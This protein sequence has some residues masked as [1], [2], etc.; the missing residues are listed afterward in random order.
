[1][2]RDGDAKSVERN[3]VPARLVTIDVLRGIAATWVV[4][5]HAQGFFR[6]NTEA[7][8]WN[9]GVFDLW[10]EP[11]QQMVAFLLF[12]TGFLGVPLFFVIS[13][14][15]IHLPFAA[16]DRR[17]DPGS[18]AKRRLTRLYPAY[19]AT[20]LAGFSMAV[21]RGGLGESPATLTN[22]AGHLFFWH[23]DWP[24]VHDGA[25]FT[26]VLWSIVVEVHFYVLYAFLLGT[27]RRIGVGT[28]SVACL[29]IGVVYRIAWFASGLEDSGTVALLEPH[30]FALARLG[31]WLLGAWAAE[32]YASGR[33]GATT[34]TRLLG[35]G[36]VIGGLSL[37][38]GSVLFVAF[39]GGAQTT[40]E[41]PTTIGLAWI[42]TSLVSLEARGEFALADGLRRACIWLGD[43]SYSLYLIHYLTIGL[44]GEI[45]ARSLGIVDK[46]AAGGTA[47]WF[48]VTAVSVTGA[49]VAAHVLYVLVERPSHQLAR[50]F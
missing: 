26:I 15:C 22:L 14:F 19:L 43:R 13:G 3:A 50:R 16:T 9:G 38:A 46:D 32:T 8:L 49:F 44:I 39:L 33:L 7:T 18:F 36:G 10:V 30:R 11:T 31:E 20:C 12:G 35:R 27:L 25:E 6:R 1:M 21:A 48:G 17:L 42:M 23:Y 5:Y 37:V 2:M 45:A 4:L 41:V 34:S 40:T 24:I 28:A 47:I 29:A